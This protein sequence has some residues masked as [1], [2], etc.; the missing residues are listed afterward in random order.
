MSESVAENRLTKLELMEIVEGLVAGSRIAKAKLWNPY[1]R[2]VNDPSYKVRISAPSGGYGPPDLIPDMPLKDVPSL[3]LR[4]WGLQKSGDAPVTEEA[5]QRERERRRTEYVIWGASQLKTFAAGNCSIFAAVA[6]GLLATPGA[7]D[8][9]A[10]TDL[11]VEQFNF[12]S[13]DGHAF[14]VVNR[15][16][17]RTNADGR[18]L[19]DPSSWGS[20]AFVIDAWYARQRQSSPGSRA[21]KDVTDTESPFYDPNFQAFLE[22]ESFLI[23]TSFTYQFLSGVPRQ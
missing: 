16:G 22:N 19:I 7:L 13:S 3:K 2:I 21:V 6:L 20:A 15:S 18:L 23:P 5:Y 8:R 1:D 17:G 9:L 11:V 10:G 12:S 14:L 4:G